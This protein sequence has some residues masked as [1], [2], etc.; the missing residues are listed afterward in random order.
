LDKPKAAICTN[1]KVIATQ[2]GRY[3]KQMLV[4]K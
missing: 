2:L 3:K 4:F 1:V